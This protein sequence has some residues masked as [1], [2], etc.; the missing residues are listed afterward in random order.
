MWSSAHAKRFV[1]LFHRWSS[2]GFCVLM[3]L[4]LVS[5]VVMLFVGYPKLLSQERLGALPPLAVPG[6]C[7]P[8]QTALA[9]SADPERVRSLAL[10]SIR[11]QP[12]YRITEGDGKLRVVD[13]TTGRRLP[14]PDAA[15]VLGSARAFLPRAGARMAG[16]VEDDRWSH[17]RALDPHR[18][19]F[20]VQM[21][22]AQAHLLYVSSA[23]GEV[24]LDAPRHQRLWNFV[25]AWLHWLYMF[26]AG[27]SDPVWTWLL[28]ILSAAGTL[29]VIAGAA[30]GIWRWRFR[31]PYKT[32]DR[33]PYRKA[34]MRWHHITGLAFGTMMI[35]WMFSGLMSMN[36]LGMF[37]AAHGRPDVAAY[38]Q[39]TPGISLATFS[40]QDALERLNRTG[41]PA[42]ELEWKVVGGL[43]YILARSASG[44]SR[45]IVDAVGGWTVREQLPRAHLLSAA[46]R[47]RPGGSMHT[48]VLETYDAY[49]YPRHSASM[50]ADRERPLPVLRLKFGDEGRTT[51]YLDPATGDVVHSAD[52]TQRT[53]RWLFNLL[54]SWDLP[55]M[56]AAGAARE[57]SLIALSLG[58]LLIAGTGVVIGYRRIRFKVRR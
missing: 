19:L 21:D 57:A 10:T 55:A 6:C 4:W 42:S 37:N 46:A 50:Y 52:S 15:A 29:S 56:L 13:A 7:V 23:T 8:A 44:G 58:G 33:T 30:A 28:I 11:G 2:I 34:A 45:V 41:F 1:Y 40:T 3:L 12:V 54:H 17:G 48:E 39:G 20:L 24:V 25:G 51:V 18:P 43:P 22:D 16:Q 31:E 26:R 53:G 32:G 9:Q 27:S 36:P 47:L 38:R 5:G 35:L 14:P 49:Y